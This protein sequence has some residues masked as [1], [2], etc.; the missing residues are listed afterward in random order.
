MTHSLARAVGPTGHVFSFDFHD[1][2]VQTATEEFRKH[3]VAGHVTC[4]QSDV[5]Q[6]GFPVRRGTPG[7]RAPGPYP[8]VV[9]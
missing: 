7:G 3:G 9:A 2:R 5:C 4:R 8:K 6:Q 1:I